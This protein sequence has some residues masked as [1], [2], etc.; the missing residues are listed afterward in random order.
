MTSDWIFL[1]IP[2]QAALCVIYWNSTVQWS[3]ETI[4]NKQVNRK[5]C[6]SEVVGLTHANR[7][8][9]NVKWSKSLDPTLHT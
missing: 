8:Q 6:S 9:L 1:C 2:K 3:V 5:P 7:Q 4:G